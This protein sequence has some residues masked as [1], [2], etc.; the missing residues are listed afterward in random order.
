[1]TSC[2]LSSG[3]LIPV[4]SGVQPR[5]SDVSHAVLALMTNSRVRIPYPASL[6]TTIC[7]FVK[8][9]G[10]RMLA[11]LPLVAVRNVRSPSVVGV[12]ALTE[13]SFMAI[14]LTAVGV[15]L[16]T[17]VAYAPSRGSNEFCF[18]LLMDLVRRR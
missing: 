7:G 4:V 12:S 11:M 1:M 16:Q 9:G 2:P 5:P 13:R 6:N 3:W 10:R 15:W 18:F 17:K 14:W 8:P